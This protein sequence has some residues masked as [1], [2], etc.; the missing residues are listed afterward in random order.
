[1]LV[2]M[3][4]RQSSGLMSAEER[5]IEFTMR[6][7]EQAWSHTRHL[8]SMRGQYLG[9]FFTAVLGV[10]AIAGPRLAENSLRTSS[11]LLTVAALALGLQLLSGFLY[12]AIIRLNEVLGYYL[13][14]ILAIKAWMLSSG[15]AVDLSPYAETPR[16]PHP[17][18]GTS[19]VSQHVL[20]VGLVAFPM[21]LIGT[22]VRSIAVAGLS[23]T[24]VACVV[25]FALA[26]ATGFAVVLGS[27][28]SAAGEEHSSSLAEVERAEAGDAEST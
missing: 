21:V 18:A 20:Q 26:L 28:A 7:W 22:I 25:A 10:T 2:R 1:M 4:D 5:G 23:A 16:P 12:L 24:T 27:A 3:P 8:E 13:K 17:W 6:E 19:G 9:F 15:T 14:I 11:A